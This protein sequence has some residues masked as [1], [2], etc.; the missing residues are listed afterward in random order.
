MHRSI[1]T[2]A[3]L[4]GALWLSTMPLSSQAEVFCVDTAT[5][6]Q[7]ALSTAAING[8]DDEV[9]IVQGTYFGNFRYVSAEGFDLSI[10]G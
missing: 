1:S 7:T 4:T 3:V 8:E 5:G 2:A 9:R 10:Q 6:L